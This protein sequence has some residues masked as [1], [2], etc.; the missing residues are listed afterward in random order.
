MLERE[1][2]SATQFILESA[3]NPEPY[4]ANVPQDFIV[5]AVYFPVPEIVSGGDTLNTYMLSYS[6]YIKFFHKDTQSAYESALAVLTALQSMKNLIPLIDENG[7]HMGRKFRTGDPSLKIIDTGA[8]Q[9]TLKWD[10][11]RPYYRE[12]V[13]KMM[14][15]YVS[16]TAKSYETAMAK[17]KIYK[18]QED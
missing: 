13:Q 11:R 14:K 12:A 2:A 15:F 8:V 1:I 17:F 9:L 6:W 3:G 10:S 7:K 4:D 16:Y 5:P 18:N